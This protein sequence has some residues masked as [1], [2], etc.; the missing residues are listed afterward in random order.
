MLA[1]R[2]VNIF[3][4]YGR[5]AAVVAWVVDPALRD[6]EFYVY[7]RMDEG[8]EWELLNTEPVFGTT[9]VDTTLDV[10]NKLQTPG[11]KVLAI[12]GKREFESPDITI[13]DKT[14]RKAY[15]VAHNIIRAKYIQARHDGIPVLYYPLTRNGKRN[16]SLD[17]DTG[18]RVKAACA[19]GDGGEGSEQDDYGTYYAGGYCRP[20]L[21]YMRLLGEYAQRENVLDTGVYDASTVMVEMLAFP[22]VRTDDLIVD[23][24]TDRRWKVGDSI[25]T[26]MV[27]GIIPVS[28]K[29]KV[30]L[31]PHNDPCYSV[32]IPDNYP[33]LV[34]NLTWPEIR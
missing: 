1:F 33:E 16:E 25:Q 10:P 27:K 28:H 6:A 19:S 2:D 31:Q 21:T 14:G 20:F 22:Y 34:R 11:Y 26:N 12:L 7:R 8:G 24:A 30:A 3:P 4:S 29:V 15:G 18:Q 9:Y 32:P 17:P 5:K 23:V 13:Y